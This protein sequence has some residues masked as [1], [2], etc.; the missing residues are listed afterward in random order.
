MALFWE[1]LLFRYRQLKDNLYVWF[2]VY[3]KNPRF[4]KIDLYLLFLY[5]GDNPYQIVKRW[6]G[7]FVRPHLLTYGETPI[8]SFMHMAKWAGIQQ[9]DKVYELGCGRGR[10]AFF[11]AEAY[12]CEVVGIDFVP[13]YIE[14]GNKVVRCFR[15]PNLH[16]VCADF[17]QEDFSSA[18]LIYLHGTCLKVEEIKKLIVLTKK[19][20]KGARALTVSFSFADYDPGG[21]WKVLSVKS[22]EMSWGQAQVYLQELS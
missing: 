11:I 4:S 21:P 20:R 3:P 19:C 17:L 9:S 5:W 13:E 16:L 8:R 7:S 12:K 6:V 22:L 1:R 14:R 2:V 18:T 10:G 15:I